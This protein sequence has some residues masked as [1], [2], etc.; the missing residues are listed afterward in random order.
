MV[1]GAV[2]PAHASRRAVEAPLSIP[3][4]ALVLALAVALTAACGSGGTDSDSD[5]ASGGDGDDASDGGDSADDGG[6]APPPVPP[7][8]SICSVA[9]ECEAVSSTCCDC[10]DFAVAA[11]SDYAEACSEVDCELPE[12]CPVVVADCVAFQCVLVCAPVTANNV[13]ENGF[14]RDALG[15]LV[16][17]CRGDPDPIFACEEDTDCTEVQADCCG[18][19][20]GGSDTA[21]A[22]SAVQ[23]YLDSLG[24]RRNP[25]CPGLPVCDAALVPR[26]VASSCTLGPA[27]D[28]GD[29]DDGD[30]GGDTGSDEDVLCGVPDFPPCPEGQ[31]CVLNHQDAEDATRMGVG[32]CHGA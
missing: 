9:D 6:T 27:D 24:C 15:C 28:G 19:A 1:D 12:N 21:V 14:E 10:P 11:D 29:G 25:A 32:T 17:T 22:T 7:A 30:G 18:C 8:V 26:C 31:V 20:L 4:A 13:C 3:R 5:E 16:D 2:N 23:D